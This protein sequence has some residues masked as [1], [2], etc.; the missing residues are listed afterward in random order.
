MRHLGF[1]THPTQN[2]RKDLRD[3]NTTC[4]RVSLN[5]DMDLHFS[6]LW[7]GIF[8]LGLDALLLLR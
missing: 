4:F 5:K 6:F 3:S 1:R 2:F 8:A 7:V